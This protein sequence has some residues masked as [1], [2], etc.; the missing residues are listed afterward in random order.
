MFFLHGK[1]YIVLGLGGCHTAA[2]DFIDRLQSVLQDK[3]HLIDDIL[4]APPADE[5]GD[6]RC[7]IIIAVRQIDRPGPA[8]DRQTLARA[9]NALHA[10]IGAALT[11]NT[12][13]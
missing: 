11:R 6:S 13:Q 8:S 4:P 9:G 3:Q 2:I 5:V 10:L 12:T 1:R 7:S